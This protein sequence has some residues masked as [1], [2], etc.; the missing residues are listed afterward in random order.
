MAGNEQKI[1]PR[2][3]RNYG[4]LTTDDQRAVYRQWADSYDEELIEEFGYIAPQ[5]AVN[6]FVRRVTDR[7][8]PVLDM[9]CGTGLAGK[10][11]D[12]AGYAHIDGIDLSPEMLE[13]AAALNVYR[14]LWEGDLTAVIDVQPIYQ[15][16]I[17]VGVFSH[18][19][20]QP[21]LIPKLLDCL[22]PGG[23]VIATV[24]G[25]GWRD[26][27]WVEL[28]EESQRQHDFKLES[29]DDIGYLTKQGIDGK[30]LTIRLRP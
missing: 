20:D 12:Q 19:S 8:A 4:D 11:L 6:A 1:D 30:L 25:K 10:L 18:K 15:A 28:L 23:L 14:Q 22:L 29:V 2:L 24:N 5:E 7:T 27:G 26:I 9:G 16:M 3:A 17:C 13:K 21:F